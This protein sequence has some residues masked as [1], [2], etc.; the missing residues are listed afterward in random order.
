MKKLLFIST[1]ILLGF[2]CKKERLNDNKE[3]LVGKW[4]LD[5]AIYYW[6]NFKRSRYEN[7]DT[8]IPGIN[9]NNLFIT[10]K[11]S[12]KVLAEVDGEESKYKMN[13]KTKYNKYVS[14]DN[15]KSNVNIRTEDGLQY[16]GDFY[17]F[18]ANFHHKG[19][20]EAN[21]ILGAVNDNTLKLNM[22]WVFFE[23]ENGGGVIQNVFKK[24]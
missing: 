23:V 8:L 4:E 21:V 24:V 1:L 18:K 14:F 10:F 3:L 12:G 6:Y 5:Y 13:F 19:E 7:F 17:L 20:S 11:K 15:E 22:G 16:L 2:S 9:A